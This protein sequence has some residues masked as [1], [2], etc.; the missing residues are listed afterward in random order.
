M[1]SK[2]LADEHWAWL[3]SLLRKVYTDAFVHGYKHGKEDKNND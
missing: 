2:K 3:E 1:T